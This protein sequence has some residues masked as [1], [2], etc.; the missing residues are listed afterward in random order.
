M[1]QAGPGTD[2]GLVWLQNSVP[3][4][5]MMVYT[6]DCFVFLARYR[7]V[8]RSVKLRNHFSFVLSAFHVAWPTSRRPPCWKFRV[9]CGVECEDAGLL[10]NWSQ[11]RTLEA[12]TVFMM[13]SSVGSGCLFFG[14]PILIMF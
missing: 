14:C 3:G 2:S 13:L 8:F 5:V 4:D 9:F 11:G 7:I 1:I 10:G 6:S 12:T